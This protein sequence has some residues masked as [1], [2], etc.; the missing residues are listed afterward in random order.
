MMSE[1]A[2]EMRGPVNGTP[3]ARRVAIGSG[4][5]AVIETYDFI[6]FGTAALIVAIAR[7]GT[8]LF[9][10]ASGLGWDD[11]WVLV[12]AAAMFPCTA[13]VLIMTKHGLGRDIWGVPVDGLDTVLQVSK[14]RSMIRASMADNRWD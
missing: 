3:E 13:A 8:R 4:V 1:A 11:Y 9:I 10:V 6:G 2:I 7:V 12:A 5:G 14:A